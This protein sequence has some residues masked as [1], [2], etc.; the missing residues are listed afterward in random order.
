MKALEK[1]RGRRYETANGLAKDVERYLNNEAVQAGPASAAYRF[2]KFARRH[3]IGLVTTSVVSAA[4]VLGTAISTWQAV[5]ATRA[6]RVA[7]AEAQRANRQAA[8]ANA[9][10]TLLREMLSSANVQ[11][12]KGNE[13]TVR[14]MLDDFSAPL[15]QRLKGQPELEA[16]LRTT[17]GDAYRSLGMR[18]QA[19]DHLE[20]ALQLLRRSSGEDSV[21]V[22]RVLVALAWLPSDEGD[23]AAAVAL[24]QDA[25]RIHR[26]R[27]S[28][29]GA[30][31]PAMV[32]LQTFHLRQKN[33]VDSEQVGQEALAIARAAGDSERGRVPGIIHRLAAVK[34]QQG[35]V[36]E[37]EKLAREAIELHRQVNGADHPQTG[38]A[39]YELGRALAGQGRSSEA[40]PCFQETLR[41]F[42]KNF[43]D[44]AKQITLVL[45]QLKALETAPSEEKQKQ[46]G[47]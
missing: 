34:I 23:Q 19:R 44:N 30:I 43:P 2:R 22:A 21:P 17:I 38:W 12:G 15:P 6:E 42:R 1:D 10:L 13:Y 7:A 5:R 3:R 37:A 46:S 14:Q 39:L 26:A 8:K 32:A 28:E 27:K 47:R 4:L 24:A 45:E 18:K 41:I 40:L 20:A 33:L 11:S 36:A 25:L 31:L 9:S 35:Q 16:A 29:A